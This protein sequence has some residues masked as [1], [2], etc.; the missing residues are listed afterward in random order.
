MKV[1]GA[2]RLVRARASLGERLLSRR[3]EIEQ[4]ILTRVY[5]V[6]DTSRIGDPEYAEGL[7]EAVS[8]AV[9]Y[10]IASIEHDDERVPPVPPVLLRQARAA[11]R[12][13]IH[14]DT[15]LRRYFAGYALLGNFLI[16]EAARENLLEEDAMKGVLRTQATLFD[17]LLAAVSEEYAREVDERLVGAEARRI[18]RVERLLAGELVDTATF[19]YNFDDHHVGIVATGL[20]A[21]DAIRALSGSLDCRALVV[22][23]GDA[24]VWA[25]LGARRRLDPSEV[26]RIAG[27]RS[28]GASIAIGE[29][30]GGLRG[31]RLTHEQARAALP[32]AV[33]KPGYPVRYSDAPLLASMLQ[34]DLLC[35]SLRELYL[36]PLERERDGGA[37]LRQTLSAYITAE[38]N[39]SSAA[40]LLG[41]SRGT[42]ANRL[43]SVESKLDRPLGSVLPQIEAA[44]QLD[45]LP[46]PP[47][48]G[49]SRAG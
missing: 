25:W 2:A 47:A 48:N 44:L 27:T 45:E 7:R 34:D 8:V 46:E 19:D 20:H 35:A 6:S 30:A 37:V 13:G 38:R 28:S 10:G 29:P 21:L 36:E 31:W 1:A 3:A 24:N 9:D 40:A 23:H 22:P 15:V 5:G 32:I 4:A 14:L 26:Q 16:E 12:T 43:R 17:R 39:V 49:R 33:R 18:E 11:A 42:I 41:V